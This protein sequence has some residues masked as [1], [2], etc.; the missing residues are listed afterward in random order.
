V[1]LKCPPAVE[2]AIFRNGGSL[3]PRPLADRIT[4]H[5]L[6]VH[7]G[8]GHFDPDVY[9]AV[10]ERMPDARVETADVGHL[11][12]MEHPA[13]VIGQVERMLDRLEDQDST[14]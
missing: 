1:E 10:A 9:R 8:R 6:F 3:D 12:L 11:M 7:A 5:T 13:F 14:G 4:A 2:A